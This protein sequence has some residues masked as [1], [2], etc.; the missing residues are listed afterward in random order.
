MLAA[1]VTSSDDAIV[2]KDL[3]GTIL[4][5]NAGAE[6]IF[7]YTAEE[8]V[9]RSITMLLP[10][11]RLNEEANI[12]AML[13]RGGRVDHYETERVAKDGHR[14]QVSLSVSPIKDASGRIVG[15]AKIARDTSVPKR[16][17]PEP[18]ESRAHLQPLLDVTNALVSTLDLPAIVAAVSSSLER[19]IAHDFTALILHDEESDELVERAVVSRRR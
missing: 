7:G 3:H 16:R 4:S 10:P 15:G 9:G 11:E 5:W 1:I 14:L 2:S 8:A 18:E 17:K 13:V 12:L 6:R 19:V